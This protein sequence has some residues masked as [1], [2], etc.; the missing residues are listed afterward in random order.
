MTTERYFRGV[1]SFRNVSV[2]K[3]T[4]SY[5]RTTTPSV[6][7]SALSARISLAVMPPRSRLHGRIFG[8]VNTL[9]QAVLRLHILCPS[10]RLL[11][12]CIPLS[13]PQVRVWREAHCQTGAAASSFML[14]VSV[15]CL[16]CSTYSGRFRR[17][18]VVLPWQP[19]VHAPAPAQQDMSA[20]VHG[21]RPS[22]SSVSAGQSSR[23]PVS[24]RVIH[25]LH[26]VS[27]LTF[28]LRLLFFRFVRVM[29]SAC[30]SAAL[31]TLS[32]RFLCRRLATVLPVSL[33]CAFTASRPLHR[34]V[35]P[36]VLLRGCLRGLSIH[37]TSTSAVL[38]YRRLSVHAA[39]SR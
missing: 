18:S 12:R 28:S 36:R 19:A 29:S 7:V 17:P 20:P 11:S 34:A 37:H 5:F 24:A 27:Q 25:R 22:S 35:R 38:D 32:F 2:A 13:L 1:I 26:R 6:P 16:C 3:Q 23:H 30:R 14:R 39:R 4:G 10:A 21:C 15:C 31:T 8:G 9:Q 33:K